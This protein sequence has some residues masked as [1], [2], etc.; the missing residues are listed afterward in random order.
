[1]PIGGIHFATIQR[2]ADVDQI[3]QQ[4]E[5]KPMVDQQNI[6]GQIKQRDDAMSHQVLQ[7]RE[8]NK[9]DNEADAREEGKGK[10]SRQGKRRKRQEEQHEEGRVIKKQAAGIDIKI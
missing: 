1:M 4:Q 9:T 6:Q 5:S 3:R 10:Y 8:G 7:S 2:T